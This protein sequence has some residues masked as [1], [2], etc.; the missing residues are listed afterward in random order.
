VPEPR[1]DVAAEPAAPGGDHEPA[2][3]APAEGAATTAVQQ[4][5]VAEQRDATR[6]HGGALP[7]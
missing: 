5:D 1:A 4:S 6:R 3:T 2:P 7:R